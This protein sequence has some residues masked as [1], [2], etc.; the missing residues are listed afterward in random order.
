MNLKSVDFAAH[1]STIKVR[2]KEL[3]DAYKLIDPTTHEE[4]ID[5]RIY[6]GRD[7][8]SSIVHC[9]LW[10]NLSELPHFITGYGSAGG[11]NYDKTSAA[12]HSALLSIGYEGPLHSG[13]SAAM[14]KELW[15]DLGLKEN[16]I[17]V[18]VFP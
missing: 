8:K 7:R 9:L 15:A 6:M 18:H 13:N 4:V 12:L 1:P 2:D 14:L 5:A 17:V 11:Y 3:R 16:P 10:L